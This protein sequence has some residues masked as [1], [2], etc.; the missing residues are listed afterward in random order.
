MFADSTNISTPGFTP[1]I[2]TVLTTQL[3][4]NNWY[5]V[6]SIGTTSQTWW[7]AVGA[8]M[9]ASH[10]GGIPPVG[11]I[12][13]AIGTGDGTG[14]CS[15]LLLS[16]E[17]V[18]SSVGTGATF[19]TKPRG[20]RINP[21][22]YTGLGTVA[23]VVRDRDSLLN[24]LCLTNTDA[25]NTAYVYLYNIRTLFPAITIGSTAST[26]IFAVLPNSTQI[27]PLDHNF[28]TGICIA[29]SNALNSAVASPTANTLIIN[30]TVSDL[31][32]A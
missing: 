15:K 23:V 12:F 19:L 17:S 27:I 6:E 7:S 26:F 30:L 29:A 32:G 31:L 14:T 18:I 1:S 25:V 11:W 22:V 21:L 2:N 10:P 20:T 3:L 5:K 24:V 28:Q 13:K 9:G 4:Q 8:N 16:Q